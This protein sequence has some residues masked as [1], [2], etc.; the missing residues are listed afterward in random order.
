[1]P[2]HQIFDRMQISMQLSINTAGP[3]NASQRC[4]TIIKRWLRLNNSDSD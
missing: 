3:T 4:T 2:L 1:M